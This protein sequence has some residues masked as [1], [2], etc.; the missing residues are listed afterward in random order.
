MSKIQ[1]LN[2]EKKVAV[3]IINYIQLTLT[4]FLYLVFIMKFQLV[5]IS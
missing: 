1:K 3:I 5:A 4:L 2:N